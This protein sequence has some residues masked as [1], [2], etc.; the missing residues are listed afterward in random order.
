MVGAGAGVGA[1]VG[2]GAGASVRHGAGVGAR[3]S[4]VYERRRIRII[5]QAEKAM[6]SE[7]QEQEERVEIAR[8]KWDLEQKRIIREHLNYDA[9][10]IVRELEYA[11]KLMMA[12]Q[13]EVRKLQKMRR[14]K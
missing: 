6:R 12:W 11:A 10:G 9:I 14:N 2:G 7:L 3:C 8:S 13:R 4:R 1:S 5:S